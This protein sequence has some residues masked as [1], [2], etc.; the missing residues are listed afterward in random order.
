MAMFSAAIAFSGSGMPLLTP[1]QS[2]KAPWCQP[3]S[4]WQKPYS[5]QQGAVIGQ[6]WGCFT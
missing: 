3:S 1:L 4:A 6:P 2:L 5:E